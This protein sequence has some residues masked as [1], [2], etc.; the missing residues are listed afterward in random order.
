MDS[1]QECMIAFL[2]ILG[3]KH[4][5]D[6]AL[7]DEV[8]KI[9][10]AI[11]SAD[12]E[13]KLLHKDIPFTETEVRKQ[14]LEN[15]NA[16]LSDAKIYVMSDSIVI[17]VPNKYTQSLAVVADIC[18][19]IQRQLYE[20]ETPVLV[21]GAIALGH[22]YMSDSNSSSNNGDK[23]RGNTFVFGQGLVAAYLAQENYAVNPRIIVEA[24]L[25]KDYMIS[26]DDKKWLK[27]DKEDGY[28]YLDTL[29]RFLLQNNHIESNVA[30][31]AEN[32]EQLLTEEFK[33]RVCYEKFEKLIK[34]NLAGYNEASVRKKYVWLK[35]ELEGIVK[36]YNEENGV[37]YLSENLYLDGRNAT[38]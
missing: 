20:L 5:I 9:F 36:R 19:V 26:I 4:I 16:V 10:N 28:I 23:T 37:I 3:F 12:K 7:F 29:G 22:F 21:R 38:Y 33:N 2:D 34:N 15:Y 8:Y 25:I 32:R 14:E 24:S 11:A 6:I 30:K 1:Y 13:V 27:E 31:D 35:K 18:Y 17:A